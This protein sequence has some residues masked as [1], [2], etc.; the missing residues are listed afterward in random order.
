MFIGGDAFGAVAAAV[1]GLACCCVAAVTG[2][3]LLGVLVAWGLGFNTGCLTTGV[4]VVCIC[5]GGG[6]FAAGCGVGALWTWVCPAHEASVVKPLGVAVVL[7]PVA[8]CESP[9]DGLRDLCR[10]P[11]LSN[12]MFRILQKPCNGL[13]NKT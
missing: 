4:D 7:V 8:V 10:L 5:L 3:V 9:P 12:K 2:A 1:A 11:D 13:R 6:G